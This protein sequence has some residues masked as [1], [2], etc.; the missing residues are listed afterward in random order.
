MSGDT[1][2][3]RKAFL[4]VGASALCLGAF[5]SAVKALGGREGLLR[6]PVVKDE[7]DFI[8]KCMR[9]YRCISVCPTGALVPASLND[10]LL[11]VRTPTLDFKQGYCDFCNKCVE[12][13]PT[14]IIEACDPN[15]PSSGRIGVAEVVP[16][17]CIAY[18]SGCVECKDQC[19]YGAITID[20]SGH[21]LVDDGLCNG[22]GV[23]ENVCPALVYRSFAGRGHRGIVIVKN[24]EAADALREEAG[25]EALDA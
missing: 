23:C 8:S 14:R 13:C 9:C 4:G 11:E 7:A 6:P 16:D 17:R 21:P 20:G 5:G 10:G 25:E 18:F 1:S 19:P 24:R 12:V 15:D 22:C 2:L 3:S